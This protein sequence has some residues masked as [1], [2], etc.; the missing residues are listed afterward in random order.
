MNQ[1][2]KKMSEYI[3]KK[4][5]NITIKNQ[6]IKDNLILFVK[7]QI[8]NPIFDNQAKESLTT[9]SSKFQIGGSKEKIE[10]SD[11]FIEKLAKIGLIDRILA[12]S[13]NTLLKISSKTDGKKKSRITGK[14]FINLKIFQGIPNLDDANWAGTSKSHETT[15][16]L[17]EGNSAA[18]MAIAGLTIV[19]KY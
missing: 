3:S 8:S 10:I 19:G 15:L 7:C 18:S 2:C 16:I 1:I 11:K 14:K 13:Q 4:H 5:K 17:T 6:I 12:Y 9:P